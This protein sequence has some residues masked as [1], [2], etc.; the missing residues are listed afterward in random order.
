MGKL[1][2][3]ICGLAAALPVLAQA[4]IDLKALDRDMAG[5]RAQVLVLGTVHLRFMPDDFNPASLNSLLDRL[6]AFKPQIITIEQESGLACDLMAR[7]PDKLGSPYN[8]DPTDKA[9]AAN[10]L[11]LPTAIARVDQT[12]KTWP[13]Q[14]TAAQRRQLAALYLAAGNH[15]SA[16]VQWLQL[17]DAERRADEHLNAALVD[18]LR[19]LAARKEESFQVAARLAARLG[20]PGVVAIDDHTGD[21][22]DVA[23]GKAYAGSLKAAW[24]QRGPQWTAWEKQVQALKKEP[25]LLPLYRYINDPQQLRL[26]ADANV[27]MQL[28]ARSPE[29]Y[30]QMW[31]AG[32]EIRNLRMIANIREAFRERP[33]ARVLA[34]VGES[35][36]PWFDTWLGQLAGVDIVDTI[37]V[38]K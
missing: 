16:Y 1:K 7:H 3:W 30:S 37:G 35:H 28:R 38:L 32:W 11:D 31:A 4:Q 22:I 13:A 9:K 6:A 27:G 10:G 20:L 8:C 2:T 17:P 14:P 23:D 25:D 21:N 15:V 29:G 24:A 33:G 18:I 19:P 34:I 12:L 5:P 36:K 26:D